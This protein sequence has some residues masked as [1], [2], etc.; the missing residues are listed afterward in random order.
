MEESDYLSLPPHKGVARWSTVNLFPHWCNGN[1]G[2]VW[3]APLAFAN[4]RT[5]VAV[6]Q[7]I[8]PSWQRSRFWMLP[9]GAFATSTCS[10]INVSH[11]RDG[12]CWRT[13]KCRNLCIPHVFLEG[14]KAWE[15][16][17]RKSTARTLKYIRQQ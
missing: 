9:I 8:S 10:L 13:Q 7:V 5:A 6:A 14:K 4:L 12:Y 16:H 15:T 11:L 1:Y 17:A 2:E 3:E